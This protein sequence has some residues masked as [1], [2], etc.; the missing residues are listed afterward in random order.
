MLVEQGRGRRA[1]AVGVHSRSYLLA[2]VTGATHHILEIIMAD[3]A[4]HT[5][6]AEVVQVDQGSIDH[7]GSVAAVG[8]SF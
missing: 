8:G 6:H 5:L 1:R 7:I 3:E 2:H 4:Q